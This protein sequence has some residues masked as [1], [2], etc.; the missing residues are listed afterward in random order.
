MSTPVT[1]P[2]FFV[3]KSGLFVGIFG[4]RKI[5]LGVM[6]PPIWDFY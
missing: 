5:R 3:S 6:T 1:A 2:G 4:A